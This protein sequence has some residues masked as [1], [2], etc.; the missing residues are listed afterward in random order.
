M[1]MSITLYALISVFIVSLI[2]LVGAITISINKEVLRRSIFFLVSL[3]VGALFGDAIIHLIPE[4]FELFE[5]T[6]HA[7]FY[8]IVGIFTFF[9]LEKFF[10]WHHHH[11]NNEEHRACAIHPVGRIILFSDGIHNL[12]DGAIIGAAYLVSIEVGIATTLA[13]ILHEIPQE[14]GDFGVLIHAGYSRARALLVNFLSGLSAVLGALAALFL[15]SFIEH[16]TPALIAI[17]AGSFLYIAGSDLV[18]ELHKTTTAR[19]SLL[20]LMGIMIGIGLMF[21]LTLVE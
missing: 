15:G 19:K 3:A 6:T 1:H 21:A 10:H 14:I 13:V 20:Q 7:A 5:D 9:V 2:S 18:P 11:G 12:L 4:A 8:I 16:A 17:A